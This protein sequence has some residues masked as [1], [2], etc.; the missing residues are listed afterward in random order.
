MACSS[1]L[2]CMLSC[3][4]CS[5]AA[6]TGY[7]LFS[8]SLGLLFSPVPVLPSFERRGLERRLGRRRLDC[9]SEGF[10]LIRLFFVVARSFRCIHHVHIVRRGGRP[11]SSE[12]R[13]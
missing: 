12:W 5:D 6:P 7:S 2:S 8:A 11:T 13:V 9:V 10:V 3:S 4:S 1:G